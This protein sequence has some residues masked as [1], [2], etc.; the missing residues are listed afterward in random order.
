MGKKTRPMDVKQLMSYP[1]DFDIIKVTTLDADDVLMPGMIVSVVAVDADNSALPEGT[2]VNDVLE[3]TD[4]ITLVEDDEVLL[5]GYNQIYSAI[6]IVNQPTFANDL[7]SII[8]GEEGKN[9]S[10]FNAITSQ[11]IIYGYFTKIQIPKT[12]TDMILIAYK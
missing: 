4:E 1:D 3:I 11:F 10:V 12:S 8:V 5:I 6:H 7:T 2:L 9:L